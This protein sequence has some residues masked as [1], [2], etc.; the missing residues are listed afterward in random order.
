MEAKKVANHYIL[1]ATKDEIEHLLDVTGKH[2]SAY[3]NHEIYNTM[4]YGFKAAYAFD[5]GKHEV[6]I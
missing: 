4:F 2:P 3:P 5:E 6:F 1:I